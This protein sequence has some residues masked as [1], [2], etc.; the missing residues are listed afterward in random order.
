MLF[1]SPSR[2]SRRNF[3][4]VLNSSPIIP[5]L[6]S[7]VRNVYF[8]LV[9]ASPHCRFSA[10]RRSFRAWR[11]GHGRRLRRTGW[12]AAWLALHVYRTSDNPADAPD[13]LT[14]SV[15]AFFA[16][17]KSVSSVTQ[18]LQHIRGTNKRKRITIT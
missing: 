18:I 13:H 6:N 7:Q 9:L 5:S 16:F 12:S 17:P 1:R 14:S 8:S 11:S 2:F 3:R 15:S 4:A 10:G